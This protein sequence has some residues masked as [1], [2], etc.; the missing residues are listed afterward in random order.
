M[1]RRSRTPRRPTRARPARRSRARPP[2]PSRSS[3][4][5]T[6][7]PVSTRPPVPARLAERCARPSA[8][9]QAQARLR[10]DRAA[11]DLRCDVRDRAREHRRQLRQRRG[12][13]RGQPHVDDRTTSYAYLAGSLG[14]VSRMTEPL[15][16]GNTRTTDYTYNANNDLT[17]QTV[18]LNG[19]ATSTI[20]RTCYD[21]ACS[22]T[23]TGLSPLATIE[24][25][26]DGVKG[27]ASGNVEDVTTDYQY[28]AYGQRTRRRAGTTPPAARCS[29]RRRP[30][31]RTTAWATRRRSSPTMPTG[32]CPPVGTT[33]PRTPPPARGPTSLPP[34]PMTPPATRSRSPIRG[35]PSLPPP[36]PPRPMTTSP[37]RAST[38]SARPCPAG[39]PRRPGSRSPSARR[40]ARTTNSA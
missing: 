27:G 4:A 3:A 18:A 16:A 20:T 29:T 25:C 26:K 11:H 38:R 35:G 34:M 23:A 8:V 1:S 22:P 36:G 2:E 19:G 24:N 33:S 9:G 15:D 21:A 7:A 6:A 13:R 39:R 31:G 37:A 28:D 17:V 10:L 5:A 40:R 12:R 30:A 14:L 32:S